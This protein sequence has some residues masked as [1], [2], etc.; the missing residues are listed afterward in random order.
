MK[1][2]HLCL[3][4]PYTDYWGYQDNLLPKYHK[5]MGLEVT[6]LT[7]NTEF[8]DGSII[9]TEEREYYLSDGERIIR[10]KYKR[11]LLN[12]VAPFIKI[13]DIY[14]ILVRENPDIIFVHGLGNLSVIQVAKYLNKHKNC[15]ALADNHVDYY[16]ES[17]ELKKS[18]LRRN[19]IV[20]S[21][22][23]LN[24]YMQKYYIKIYGVTPWRVKYSQDVFGIR[25]DKCDLLVLGADDEKIRYDSKSVIREEIRKKYHI[26]NNAFLIVTGGKI[27]IEKNVHLLIKAVENIPE[28]YLIVFG[29]I[30]EQVEKIIDIGTIN[31]RIK[32]IGWIKSDDVYDYF[33]ASDL[34][35]FPGTHSVL[36]EQSCA[37][38]V[39]GIF[40]YWDGMDHVNVEGNCI[41]LYEDTVD[42]IMQAINRVINEKD[43]YCSMKE[44]AKGKARHAFLYSSIAKKSIED[45]INNGGK[46]K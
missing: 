31:S 26:P 46:S 42:E 35:V 38:G 11:G 39:P 33:L 16:N 9:E 13:F 4:A 28:I 18:K 36:W 45:V 21:F 1:I 3:Q 40:K 8:D 22:K 5:K 2:L 12:K 41:F 20:S 14:N 24:R 17:P 30:D 44:A 37:S 6:V 10:K 43:L 25:N 23:I 7:T 32:L 29:K 27:T 34:A 15:K 19:I